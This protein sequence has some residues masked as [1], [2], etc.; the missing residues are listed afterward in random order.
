MQKSKEEEAAW[1][2]DDLS[3]AASD[4]VSQL[5]KPGRNIY[6]TRDKRIGF[7]ALSGPRE[8]GTVAWGAA[9]SP[10][11]LRSTCPLLKVLGKVSYVI[12]KR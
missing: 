8:A 12:F 4:E 7:Q 1:N 9:F 10:R 6:V 3:V 11:S 2:R 5:I